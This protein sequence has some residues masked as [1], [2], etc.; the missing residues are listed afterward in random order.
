MEIGG[1]RSKMVENGRNSTQRVLSL[2]ADA[3]HS[4][5]LSSHL[6]PTLRENNLQAQLVLLLRV[7]GY[8]EYCH[9]WLSLKPQRIPS[10]YQPIS[11]PADD[12][13]PSSSIM[14]TALPL[15]ESLGGV[16]SLGGVGENLE[17]VV[18]N[19]L[20]SSESSS[21]GIIFSNFFPLSC[22]QPILFHHLAWRQRME[23]LILCSQHLDQLVAPPDFQ[24][25][26]QLIEARPE[27][28]Q[29]LDPWPSYS[30]PPQQYR[31]RSLLIREGSECLEADFECFGE[32]HFKPSRSVTLSDMIDIELSVQLKAGFLAPLSIWRLLD[33]WWHQR[34]PLKKIGFSSSL[35]SSQLVLCAE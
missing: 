1:N 22:E 18:L 15:E 30:S 34:W 16:N 21:T 27:W 2:L 26:V 7:I 14:V 20:S 19:S 10:T 9:L 35:S 5:G 13:F 11:I 17:E 4:A 23:E 28:Q 12:S 3:L 8:S 32:F 25:E 6:S 33:S 31:Q 24:L 29:G